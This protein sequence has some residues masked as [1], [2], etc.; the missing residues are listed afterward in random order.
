MKSR[1]KKHLKRITNKSPIIAFS[2]DNLYNKSDI[3]HKE[4]LHTFNEYMGLD[5]TQAFSTKYKFIKEEMYSNLIMF[6]DN[7]LI[8]GNH[9]Y[10]Y[11]LLPTSDDT[12]KVIEKENITDWANVYWKKEDPNN[13]P[14]W[15]FMDEDIND[16]FSY[17]IGKFD[18]YIKPY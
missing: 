4:S 3:V 1:Y 7:Y 2:I 15:R 12:Y 10:I 17:M 18:K 6:I 13:E 16:L 5:A 11:L 14:D 9:E 8:C